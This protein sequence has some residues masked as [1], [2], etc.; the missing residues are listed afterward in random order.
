M[1]A[2][3]ELQKKIKEI[4]EANTTL[5]ALWGSAITVYDHVLDEKAF[6]YIWYDANLTNEWD[7]STED[8]WECLPRIHVFDSKETSKFL[9]QVMGTIESILHNNHPLTLDGYNVVL[10]QRTTNQVIRETDGQVWHGLSS[11]RALIE[12]N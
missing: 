12:E 1:S 2:N 11:F 5:S 7:T 3:L 10:L 4:L 6:P 9:R 8:G